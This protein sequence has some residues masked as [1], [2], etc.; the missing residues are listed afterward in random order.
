MASLKL[1]RV[2]Y[3]GP[4]PRAFKPGTGSRAVVGLN[5]T[6]ARRNV[7]VTNAPVRIDRY[8]V[9]PFRAIEG[10]RGKYVYADACS[11]TLWALDIAATPPATALVGRASPGISSFSEDAD[12]ELYVVE[13][14]RRAAVDGPRTN[15]LGVRRLVPGPSPH[16]SEESAAARLCARAAHG[17]VLVSA[18]VRA[19][20]GEG[21]A[22][23]DLGEQD[24]KGLPDPIPVFS[25]EP[26]AA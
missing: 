26:Q 7:G 6:Q 8:D 18:S 1:I 11:G 17:E 22:V 24:I 15:A 16:R 21:V 2:A 5:S 25:L 4:R 19:R 20:I 14:H 23:R 13:T 10:L 3:L 12:G 9:P